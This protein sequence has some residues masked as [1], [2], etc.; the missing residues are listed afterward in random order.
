M[1]QAFISATVIDNTI[2]YAVFFESFQRRGEAVQLYPTGTPISNVLGAA[3]FGCHLAM[4][5]LLFFL[6][7]LTGEPPITSWWNVGEPKEGKITQQSTTAVVSCEDLSP[8][9]LLN[10]RQKYG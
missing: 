10:E 5:R 7:H 8:H 2:F 1:L 3:L 9:A 6:P 4:H